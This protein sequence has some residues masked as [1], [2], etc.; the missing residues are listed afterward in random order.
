MK[1]Y[2]LT[3]DGLEKEKVFSSMKKAQDYRDGRIEKIVSALP[4][5]FTHKVSHYAYEE[6]RLEITAP[7]GKKMKYVY[8]ITTYNVL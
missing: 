3:F 2:M 6:T 1:V 7:S 4:P 8:K 5:S